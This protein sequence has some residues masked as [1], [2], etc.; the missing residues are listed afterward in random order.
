MGQ[1]PRGI[2][3]LLKKASVDPAFRRL[4]VEKRAQSAR[5]IDLELSEAEAAMLAGFPRD[6]LE[7]IIDNT[8]VKPEHRSVFLGS[9]GRIM[10]ATVI[11]STA[12]VALVPS[13][14]HTA[15]ISDEVV[16]K[17]NERQAEILRQMEA[18]R[19]VPD[20]ND[21]SRHAD[22]ASSDVNDPDSAVH[23]P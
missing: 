6:Q 12:I 17:A 9:V 5:E 20:A 19:I 11:A 4:L 22:P 15:R 23:E 10:L 1:I 3:V 13:M 14:G 16:R 8:K 7:K 18:D 2:E 21:G